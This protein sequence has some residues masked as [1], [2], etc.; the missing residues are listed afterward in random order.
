[1]NLSD[2]IEK[3]KDGMYE[4]EDEGVVNTED[5]R[6]LKYRNKF[7]LEYNNDVRTFNYEHEVEYFL[8]NIINK[9]YI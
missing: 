2:Q 9:R 8:N 4:F 5:M 1:M 3:I 7:C 6:L